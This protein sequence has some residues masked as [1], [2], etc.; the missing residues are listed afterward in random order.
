MNF[1]PRETYRSLKKAIEISG[2]ICLEH[3]GKHAK[4]RH[5]ITKDW[6]PVAGSPSD[7]RSTRNFKAALRH[8]VAD[9]KG[10]IYAKTGHF[11]IESSYAR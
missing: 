3:G 4:V 7:H 5:N 2:A 1:I 9:G 11:P 6:I 8:L 10:I